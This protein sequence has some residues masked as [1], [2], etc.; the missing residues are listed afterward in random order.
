MPKGKLAEDGEIPSRYFNVDRLGCGLHE[1]TGSRNYKA[2]T[3][4]NI[5]DS[6]ATLVLRFQGAGRV[7]G[8]GTKLTIK[9]LQKMKKPY[10]LFDPSRVHH[11]PKAVRWICETIVGEDDEAKNIEILNVAGPRES[12][13]PGIYDKTRIFMDDVLGYV[14]TYQRS[15]V[16]I[17]A[18]NKAERQK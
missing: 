16:K 18:L 15:G 17:W 12:G 11:V 4:R 6:D 2:R 3:V 10:R 5:S 14:Y 13:S 9:T 1:H 8:P 7:L